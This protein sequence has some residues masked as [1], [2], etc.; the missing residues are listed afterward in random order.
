MHPGEAPLRALKLFNRIGG[1]I[2]SGAG[3]MT[4]ALR[5]R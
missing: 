2:L 4:A 5:H 3:V 1:S